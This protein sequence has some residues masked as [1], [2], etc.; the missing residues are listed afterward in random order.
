[1]PTAGTLRATTA[2]SAGGQSED[3]EQ[4]QRIAFPVSES[5]G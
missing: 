4:E 1:M 5:E 2:T 3:E